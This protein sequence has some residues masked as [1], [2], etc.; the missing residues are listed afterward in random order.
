V[1][2][3]LVMT[4][5]VRD[6]WRSFWRLFLSEAIGTALLLLIGLS[7]VIVM[8]ATGSPM[9]R[10]PPSEGWRQM[11]T[12]FLFGS[13]GALIALPV[14]GKESGAYLN[15]V[16]TLDILCSFLAMTFVSVTLASGAIA[17]YAVEPS[18]LMGSGMYTLV[19]R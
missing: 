4:V 5:Q 18:R 15:P 9:A 17:T 6:S 13:T 3:A 10:L 14:L 19:R 8:F 16:V 2:R 12:G 1:T 11:I 7:L